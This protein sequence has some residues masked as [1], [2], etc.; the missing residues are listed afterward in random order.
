MLELSLNGSTGGIV[1]GKKLQFVEVKKEK[2][3]KIKGET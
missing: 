1:G 2:T 3:R